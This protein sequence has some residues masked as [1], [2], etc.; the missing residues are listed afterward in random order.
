MHL[1]FGVVDVDQV[2]AQVIAHGGQHEGGEKGEGG[3]IAYCVDP[4]GNG[5]CV[6][7]E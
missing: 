5:F 2:V 3:A 4:F 6:I 1:D 7:R